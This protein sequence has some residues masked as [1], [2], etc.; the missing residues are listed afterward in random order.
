MEV[1]RAIEKRRSTREYGST[2]VEKHAV[3]KI[4]RAGTLAP[5]GKNGQ[6]WRFAVVQENKELLRK[7]A[8]CTIYKDFVSRTD[9]LIAVFLD[10]LESYHYIK[11]CQAVGAC[12]QN[13]LLAATELHLGACWIGEILS[14]D[15]AVK[16]L[17][18]ISNRYDLMAVIAVG[19]QSGKEESRTT[20]KSFGDCTLFYR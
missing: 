15:I 5:S 1:M 17:L 10:K 20:R 14:R 8:D 6:P 12:I 11:D 19:Q 2:P 13:M 7:V 16:K 9:C 18:G 4:L 3:E